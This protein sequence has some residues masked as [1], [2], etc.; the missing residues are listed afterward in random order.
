MRLFQPEVGM[1]EAGG[2]GAVEIL[3]HRRVGDGD[4][5]AGTLD[6]AF[7]TELRHSVLSDDVLDHVAGGYDTGTLCEDRLDLRHT[8]L[9]HG[10]YG[11]E[12]LSAFRE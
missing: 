6:K 12:G 10:R 7:S 3:A 4:E 8:L 11:Y 1:A 5:R 9:G 2:C